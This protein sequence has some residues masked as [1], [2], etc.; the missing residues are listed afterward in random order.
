[1]D[2]FARRLARFSV[3]VCFFTTISATS[4]ASYRTQNFIVSAPDGQLAQAVGDAAEGFRRDLAIYWLG[5]EL[6]PWPGPC[7]IRVVS[8]PNLAAQGV[9]QYNRAPVRDFQMEV[10]G[11]PQRILDSVLPHEVTHTVLA[12]HFGQP[13]P[14]WADEG[15]CTTVEHSSEKAKHEMKLREFL[16]SG[17]GIAMNRL[18]LL[19]EYPQDILPMYAQGYSVCRFLIEQKSPR[20]F[21]DFLSDYIREPSW[22]DN[23]RKHYGYESLAELQER[24]LAWVGDGGGS[25]ALY[26]K[27]SPNTAASA[28]SVNTAPAMK[29]AS[30]DRRGRRLMNELTSIARPSRNDRSTENQNDGNPSE[31]SG[32]YSRQRDLVASHPGNRAIDAI[33]T[34]IMAPPSVRNANDYYSSAS[35]QEEQGV[36]R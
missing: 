14:R 6:P 18:F 9:T 31:P 2:A 1:M 24:W 36:R 26:V 29:T 35:V 3:V 27:N 4:A 33:G 13:L 21:V 28:S 8:G 15:I 10:V 16:A 20:Q 30:M 7:P 12:S 17:R 19:A 23:I 22:T 34:E 11:T 32:W 5:E 25:V